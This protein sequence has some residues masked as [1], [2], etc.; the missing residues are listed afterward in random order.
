MPQRGQKASP[1]LG[2]APHSGQTRSL[3]VEGFLLDLAVGDP[4]HAHLGLTVER[5]DQVAP[6]RVV[7]QVDVRLGGLGRALRVR[8]VDAD[9]EPVVVELVGRA[10]RLELEL[11]PVRRRA[12]VDRSEDLLDD[13]V[14]SAQVAAALVGRILARMRDELVPV[15]ARDPHQGEG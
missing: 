3:D 15:R 10:Q 5:H 4:P 11:V 9:L 14:A 1:P 6:V 13:A 12:L 7:G 8:V 2:A